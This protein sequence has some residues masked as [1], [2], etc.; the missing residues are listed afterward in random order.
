MVEQD[1][2]KKLLQNAELAADVLNRFLNQTDK[3]A[4]IEPQRLALL[5]AVIHQYIH[6]IEIK[7]L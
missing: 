4:K 1:L 5:D 2:F 3:T 6:Y 7:H